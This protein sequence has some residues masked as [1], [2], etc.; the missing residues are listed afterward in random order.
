[1]KESILLKGVRKY[2][3]ELKHLSLLFFVLVL[4]QISISIINKNSLN[5]F[6][7]NVH[8]WY[9]RDSA[10]RFANITTT[11]LELIVETIK[12]QQVLNE[13]DKMKIIQAFNVILSSQSLQQRIREISLIVSKNG[14]TYSIKDGD[15]LYSFLYDNKYPDRY[16]NIADKKS[17]DLYDKYK[18]EIESNERIKSVLE[19]N[20][21]FHIFV[22]FIIRGEFVGALYVKYTPDLSQIT[23]ELTAGYEGVGLIYSVLIFLGFLGMYFITSNTIDERDEVQRLLFEEHKEHLKEKIAHENEALFTKRIY[24]THHKA[25]KI[26]G[27]IKNDIMQF[28][29]GKITNRILKYANFISRVIYDMKWYEPPINTIRSPIFRTNLNEVIK[30]LKSNIFERV[31]VGNA[32]FKMNLFLDENLPPV[33]INEYVIWEIL[34]PIIQNSI[35]HGNKE[36]LLIEITTKYNK[37]SRNSKI[38]I[39]DNGDGIKQE[40]L[41][42]NEDGIKY[43]FVENVSTKSEKGRNRGYGCF[44]AYKM[45]KEMC[46]WE[47]DA[48]NVS[49]NGARFILSFKN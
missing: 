41:E 18:G 10:E 48:E 2:R 11:S 9:K 28:E 1:M 38:I 15:L 34:E 42:K 39:Q 33:S 23:Q 30:F 16:I 4:F 32:V 6:S 8:E 27:F 47:L 31:T 20:E 44:L 19:K 12:T 37:E 14:K 3:F 17:K 29:Q 46:G 24:H 43:L 21:I 49:G 5:D 22:P 40:L 45:A 26:M 13:E 7:E 35:D 25:E 36:E